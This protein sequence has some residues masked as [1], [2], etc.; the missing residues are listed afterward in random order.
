VVQGS[1]RW[2]HLGFFNFQTSELMKIGL[3]LALAK[4]FHDIPELPSRGFT[5]RDLLRPA[6]PLYA[7]GATGALILF[8]EKVPGPL[9]WRF[10]LLGVCLVWATGTVLYALRSGNTSLHALLSP[11]ILVV[12][13]AILIFRQP[14]LGTALVLFAIA[15]SM[16]LFM[17]VRWLSLLIAGVL[18]TALAVASWFFL[19]KGYQKER[20]LSF[21]SPASDTMGSGYHAHQSM[22]A[23]GSGLVSGKGY[24]ESTQTLFK[25]LPEQHT[26]FVFSV[27]AEEW[28]FVGCTVVLLLFIFLLLQ[29]VDIASGARDRFGT[30][31][32]VGVAGMIFWQAFVNIG[33]VTGLLPVVGITLPLWSYGGSSMLTSMLGIGLVLSV[34]LRRS[35]Y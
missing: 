25:F 4:Y 10:V 19:L 34:S 6:T 8:W 14:D 18:L 13:P 35:A 23:V 3:I 28:G 16:I 2:L 20:L 30:L 9:H 15:A 22:I 32:V 11:V 27:W 26:D 12:L 7:A 29:L 33:M 24:G 1:R 5:L 21:V 31:L 17:K